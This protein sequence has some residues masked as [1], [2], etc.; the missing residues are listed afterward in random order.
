V[1]QAGA[2]FLDTDLHKIHTVITEFIC[3]SLG[4]FGW[5]AGR[6]LRRFD[7]LTAG[8]LRI[9]RHLAKRSGGRA[10]IF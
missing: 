4:D 8:K 1:G 10:Q 7:M 2:D 6:V 3:L 9:K 5:G